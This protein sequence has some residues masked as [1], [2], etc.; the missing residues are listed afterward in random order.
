VIIALYK[1]TFT[2]PYHT[3]RRVRTQEVSAHGGVQGVR[4]LDARPVRSRQLRSLNHVVVSC[5][6]KIFDVNTSEIAAECTKMC[7][8]TDIADAVAMR[9]DKSSKRYSLNSS[10]VCEM[11]SLIVKKIIQ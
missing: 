8:V 7:G 4:G 3:N 5:A 9:R 10:V 1:S 2:I 11:C 6:K